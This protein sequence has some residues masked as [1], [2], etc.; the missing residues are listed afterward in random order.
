MIPLKLKIRLYFVGFFFRISSYVVPL[1]R[2]E[3][4]RI[5]TADPRSS[6]PH[7]NRT[8]SNFIVLEI[9]SQ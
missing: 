4:I 6:V 1:V 8:D 9:S 3:T 2:V 5:N 7:A